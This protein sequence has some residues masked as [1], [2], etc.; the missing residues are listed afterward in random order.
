MAD[1]LNLGG[2]Q[3]TPSI[4]GAGLKKRYKTR[5]FGQ[6]TPLIKGVNLTSLIK[7][8]WVV[9]VWKLFQLPSL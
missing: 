4:K 3:A 1:P 2:W 8:V 9:R 6:S 5:G 7:G